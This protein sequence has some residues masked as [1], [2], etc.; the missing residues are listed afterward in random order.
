MGELKLVI[1]V[2]LRNALLTWYKVELRGL[3]IDTNDL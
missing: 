1:L 3:I 2:V